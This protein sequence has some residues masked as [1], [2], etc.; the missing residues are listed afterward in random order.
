MKCVMQVVRHLTCENMDVP[1]IGARRGV[2]HALPQEPREVTSEGKLSPI[3]E[4]SFCAKNG[5]QRERQ[6]RVAT[7]TEDGHA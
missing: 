3:F 4:R 2:K 7:G 1:K 5:A 6:T